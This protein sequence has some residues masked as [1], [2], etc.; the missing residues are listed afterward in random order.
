MGL[1]AVV[2]EEHAR[3]AVQLGD[4]DAFG[5]VDDERT[6]L[7]HQ[8]DFT[9]VHVVFADFLDD[10]LG[11]LTVEDGQADARTQGRGES[12][13]AQ[14]AFRHVER[15]ITQDIMD[16]VETRV[17]VVA[18]DRKDRTERC[19][20]ARILTPVERHAEL[21]EVGV[22]V[23]LRRQQEWDVENGFA[24]GEAFANPL[25]LSK[26]IT[27]RVSIEVGGARNQRSTAWLLRLN[28]DV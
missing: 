13:A 16:K 22:R 5:T 17:T 8:R 9:H 12:N 27:H 7:G 26:R 2:L 15:R 18:E 6:V 11:G 10:R 1:A 4:D 3:A 24:L 20:E 14:L 21:Q 19:F 25:L 23:D 28:V